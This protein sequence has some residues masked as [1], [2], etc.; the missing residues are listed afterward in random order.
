MIENSN[1]GN[2]DVDTE[3]DGGVWF[4]QT[5]GKRNRPSTG[6]PF[7]ENISKDTVR[8]ITRDAFKKISADEK[9]VSPF[10][11]MTSGL[12]SMNS[13]VSEL[14]DDLHVIMLN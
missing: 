12:G 10:E 2:G 11:I 13:T 9:L 3:H 14:E 8:K 4:T 7:S 1:F 5:R 6:W